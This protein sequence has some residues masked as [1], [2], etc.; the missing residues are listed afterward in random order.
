[1]SMSRSVFI[2]VAALVLV[3]SGC[4]N[5]WIPPDETAL[6][7]DGLRENR[8]SRLVVG[9]YCGLGSRHGDLAAPPVDALDAICLEHDACFIAGRNR[10]DCNRE[11]VAATTALIADPD[12]APRLRRRAR[13][14]R[15]FF[16]FMTPVCAMFPQGFAPPRK[17][18]VLQR[19]Y[20]STGSPK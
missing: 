13:A 8:P 9:N 5:P 7:F 4:A 19:R 1:M 18:D 6:S 2:A 14:V 3:L 12:T 17:K 20:Q 15:D 11:L 10:C 16:P